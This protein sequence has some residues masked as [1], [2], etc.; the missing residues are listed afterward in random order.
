MYLVVEVEVIDVVV[1]EYN[2]DQ[3]TPRIYTD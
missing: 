2:S 3:L 1:M